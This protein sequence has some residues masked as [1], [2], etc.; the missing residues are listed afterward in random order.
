MNLPEPKPFDEIIPLFLSYVPGR[1]T[2][3]TTKLGRGFKLHNQINHAKNAVSNAVT[4]S[5]GAPHD[6]GIWELNMQAQEWQLLYHIKQG[7]RRE[8]FPW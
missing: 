1:S 2:G 6:M 3:N 4:Y 8:D 7:T 5:Q